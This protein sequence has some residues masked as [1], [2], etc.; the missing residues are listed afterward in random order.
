MTTIDAARL[1]TASASPEGDDLTHGIRFFHGVIV[2][3]ML[4][5]PI[6]ALVWWAL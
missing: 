1:S 4:S 2:A 5:V 3:L 6:W